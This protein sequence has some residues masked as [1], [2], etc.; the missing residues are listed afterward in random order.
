MYITTGDV[1][2]ITIALTMSLT[3]IVTT[4]LHNIRLTRARDEYREAYF[5]LADIFRHTEKE[6]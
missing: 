5:Q 6:Q 3:L 4:T 2:V 1:A